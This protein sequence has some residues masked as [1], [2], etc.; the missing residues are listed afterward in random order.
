METRKKHIVTKVE[1]LHLLGVKATFLPFL[2]K[3]AKVPGRPRRDG[4]TM[5]EL[6][7]LFTAIRTAFDSRQ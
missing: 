6:R 2:E 1:A 5:G 3:V 4:Y 7:R